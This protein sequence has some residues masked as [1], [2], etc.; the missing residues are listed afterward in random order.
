[1]GVGLDL[2]A[3]LF[4]GLQDRGIDQVADDLFDVTTDIADLGKF[5][6][7]DLEEGGLGQLGQTAGDFGFADAGGADHQ[8]VL[9]IDLVAQIIVQ[10]LA[11]PAVAQGDGHGALGVLL[12]DDETV[13]LRDNL[14]GGQVGHL[15]ILND[16]RDVW[17]LRRIAKA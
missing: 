6:G 10:L 14:A 7:F 16:A 4:A 11:P 9:G 12:A 2:F 15:H 1:M 17:A 8:D 13:E 3:H 5:G